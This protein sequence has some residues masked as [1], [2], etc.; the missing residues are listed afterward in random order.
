MYLKKVVLCISI[1]LT[2]SVSIAL[3]CNG[4]LYA[5]GPSDVSDM[6]DDFN[7]NCSPGDRLEIIDVCHPAEQR[8]YLWAYQ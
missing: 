4:T 7:Q 2:L 1:L 6:A 5:C 3:A 8:Y